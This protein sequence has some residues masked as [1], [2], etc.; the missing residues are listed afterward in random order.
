MARSPFSRTP[1]PVRDGGSEATQDHVPEAADAT[2]GATPA[3]AR[4]GAAT[5]LPTGGDRS[6]RG[7]LRLHPSRASVLA[8]ALTLAL[9]IGLSAQIRQT[10][11]AGLESLRETELVGILDGVT[12]RATRL[13][14]ETHAL[15]A[16]LAR[17]AGGADGAEAERRARER[18]GDLGVLA[19]SVPA[20]GPGVTVVLEGGPEVLPAASF[21][22]L[23]QELRDAGAEAV[24]IGDV[25]VV[26]STSFVDRD[27]RVLVDGHEL[28]WPV[29][30]VAI[31]DGRTLAS[32]LAIPGGVEES[33]RQA[34]GRIRVDPSERVPVNALHP[35]SSHRYARPVTTPEE[36]ATP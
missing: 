28:A 19:G 20:E 29:R 22:D 13:Q 24:Q 15:E 11:D 10:H 7:L 3:A 17:L 6:G 34:G 32:A 5:T 21:L 1:R 26:A 23:V 16:E 18:L 14:E 9:G 33:T 36:Q 4:E 31:G 35:A 12:A 25:R 8:G 2:S 30:V 27:G